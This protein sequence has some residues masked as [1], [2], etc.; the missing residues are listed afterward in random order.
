MEAPDD[1]GDEG[2]EAGGDEGDKDDA[3]AVGVAEVGRVVV[4]SRDDDAAEHE[5]PVSHGDVDL[6]EEVGGGVDGLDLGEV[7]CAHDLG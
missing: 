2:D 1:E 4:D 5:E 6:A 7:R 3:D